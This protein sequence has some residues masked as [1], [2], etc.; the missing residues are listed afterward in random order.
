MKSRVAS[1]VHA[2][3]R[4]RSYA[5]AVALVLTACTGRIGDG[6]T[7]AGPG[8]RASMGPSASPTPT[9]S[10]SPT[11]APAELTDG[12]PSFAPRTTVQLRRLTTEQYWASVQALLGQQ[13]PGN[14]RGSVM[15]IAAFTSAL[16]VLFATSLGGW[17]FD[18]WRAGGPFVMIAVVNALVLLV[19]LWVRLT[20]PTE[21]PD[22]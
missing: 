1:G 12:W 19:A 13:A 20:T 8:P 2:P 9:P 3:G 18:H 6:P 11:A 14:L 4:L 7:P 5:T 10:P 21:R 15:G 22:R 16:G 17:L